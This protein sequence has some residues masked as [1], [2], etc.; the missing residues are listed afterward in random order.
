MYSSGMWFVVVQ[1]LAAPGAART[2]P[3]KTQRAPG[4]P[5]SNLPNCTVVL[6]TGTR[7]VSAGTLLP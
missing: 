7:S 5:S 2:A 1:F 4:G 6:V 3:Q